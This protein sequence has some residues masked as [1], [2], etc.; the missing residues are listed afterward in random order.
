LLGGASEVW[1]TA[2]EIRAR[3]EGWTRE[4]IKSEK[5]AREDKNA[6]YVDPELWEGL[7]VFM[8]MQTQWNVAAGFGGSSLVGLR[9]EALPVVFDILQIK[10]RMMAFSV[11]QRLESIVRRG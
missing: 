2:D 7:N 4:Q 10:N 8:H 3:C 1:T 9:Y 5:R 11:V 6:V